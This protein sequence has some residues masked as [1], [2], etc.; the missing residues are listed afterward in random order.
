MR[1]A[2]KQLSEVRA[3]VIVSVLLPSGEA[4]LLGGDRV[5]ILVASRAAGGGLPP[6]VFEG[7]GAGAG[8]AAGV[9]GGDRRLVAGVNPAE[10]GWGPGAGRA[11][12][13]AGVGDG[14]R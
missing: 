11:V 13:G 7:S 6:G 12:A 14:D 4:F 1:R 2:D 5:V 9:D 8:V 10:L 3:R